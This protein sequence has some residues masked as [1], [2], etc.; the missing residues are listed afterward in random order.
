M[1]REIHYGSGEISRQQAEEIIDIDIESPVQHASW[2]EFYIEALT[3]YIVEQSE[4]RGYITVA[5]ADWLIG[6]LDHSGRVQTIRGMELLANILDKS[7]WSPISLIAYAL[8]QVKNAVLKGEGPLRDGRELKKAIVSEA[9]VERLRLLLVAFGGDGNFAITRAEAEILFDINQ[10]TREA[11]NDPAWTELFTKAIANYV[12]GASDYHVPNRMQALGRGQWFGDHHVKSGDLI[13]EMVLG[14]LAEVWDTYR[15]Q[16]P[17]E[18]ELA[19]LERK[20]IEIITA[21]ANCDEEAAWLTVRILR[22]GE[23]CENEKAL[24]AF[25]RTA[26]PDIHPSLK[27]IMADAA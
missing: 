24:L 8:D 1:R 18:R 13:S 12:M 22:D 14:S 9:D 6:R 25:I 11:D 10:M 21:E 23:I 16:S 4:P 19:K 3:N 17:E 26:Q 5:N 20:K 7:R 2:Q 27:P 15:Q